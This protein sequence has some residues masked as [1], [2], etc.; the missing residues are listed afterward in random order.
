MEFISPEAERQYAAVVRHADNLVV[1]LD[2][3]GTLAP[4]IDNPDVAHIHPDAPQVLV[5]LAE[6]VRAVAVITGRPARQ[7]LALG[8]L[9]DV[10]AAVGDAGREFF[11]LGQYG[12]ERWTSQ[13][14]RVISPKPPKGLASFISN[15]SRVLR[16][17][18]AQEAWVEE[19]G[20]AVAVHTRRLPDAQAVFERLLPVLEEEAHAH[21]LDV[22][23]GR[24]VIEVRAH[25]MHKGTAVHRLAEEVGAEAFIFGGD[26]LG[27]VEAFRAVTE[28]RKDGMPALLICSASDDQPAI[29]ELASMADLVV[30]GPDG[31]M[32]FLR[33]LTADI[34]NS[35]A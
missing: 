35:R 26:D 8:G 10:G 23:P 11:V 6:Q 33:Q 24:L 15:L 3:D 25:G 30:P 16:R 7:A 22:E 20:L 32:A 21:D 28:L 5:A 27:D 9:D 18:D 2:F 31:V 12:N 17:Y 4:I 1:G 13:D 14:R 19:K 34:R 29:P